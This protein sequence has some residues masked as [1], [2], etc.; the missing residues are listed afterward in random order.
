MSDVRELR[1]LYQ[2]VILEH[3]KKPENSVRWRPPTTKR[4]ASIRCV[5]TTTRCT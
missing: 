5:A 4:K 1:D 2:E 3:S